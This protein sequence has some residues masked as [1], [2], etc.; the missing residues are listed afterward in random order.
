M[1]EKQ[2]CF[3]ILALVVAFLGVYIDCLLEDCHFWGSSISI[4]LIKVDELFLDLSLMLFFGPW[5]FCDLLA[6]S[7][8][9]SCFAPCG[10][11]NTTLNSLSSSYH[12]AESASLFYEPD[13]ALWFALIEWDVLEVTLCDF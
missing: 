13:L 10:I 1:E 4:F 5:K 9:R 6:C 8:S 7:L 3:W 11:Q 2:G 12:E